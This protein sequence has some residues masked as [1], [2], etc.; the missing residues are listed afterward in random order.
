M[1][2]PREY[3]AGLLHLLPILQN[4]LPC[5]VERWLPAQGDFCSAGSMFLLMAL[6]RCS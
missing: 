4:L 1:G 5:H 6:S 2:W 3:V